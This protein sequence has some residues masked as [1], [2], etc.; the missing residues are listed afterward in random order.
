MQGGSDNGPVVRPGDPD[1]SLLVQ[2][3]EARQSVGEPMPP[4][5]RLSEEEVDLIRRWIAEG[6]RDN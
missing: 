4:E 3:V 1:G 5:Y 2:K 6:A